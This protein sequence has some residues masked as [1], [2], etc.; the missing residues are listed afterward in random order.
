[1][2]LVSPQGSLRP[3]RR[4]MHEYLRSWLASC[5]C[6]ATSVS[7]SSSGSIESSQS[8]SIGGSAL[9]PRVSADMPRLGLTQPATHQVPHRHA[10]DVRPAPAPPPRPSDS[11]HQ[12]SV[13]KRPSA[14]PSP[15]SLASPRSPIST[16]P[17]PST[18]P[19]LRPC[20]A[21]RARTFLARKGCPVPP[22]TG[23]ASD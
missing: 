10:L 11:F 15:S 7:Y 13:P 4:C 1:M 18:L 3:D 16:L 9:L 14:C 12:D 23:L 21:R 17:R 6:S 2:K 20:S 22:A 5:S 19:I 8:T